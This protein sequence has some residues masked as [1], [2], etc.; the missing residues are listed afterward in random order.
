MNSCYIEKLIKSNPELFLN[1]IIRNDSLAYIETLQDLERFL[2]EGKFSILENFPRKKE[3]IQKMMNY[4]LT[5]DGP[6]LYMAHKTDDYIH[7][8][9]LEEFLKIHF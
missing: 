5:W 8:D 7:I 1:G 2:L 6:D 9:T 4:C 3:T